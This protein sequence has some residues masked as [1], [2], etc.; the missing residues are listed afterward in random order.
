MTNELI[1]HLHIGNILKKLRIER[2]ETMAEVCRHLNI[3]QSAL[4]MYETGRRMPRDEIKLRLS[5]YYGRPV[6]DIFFDV[7][8]H[9]GQSLDYFE[10]KD[11]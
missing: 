3:S 10:G 2:G 5:H 1:D 7:H 8:Q 11:A 9:N 4:G 6:E